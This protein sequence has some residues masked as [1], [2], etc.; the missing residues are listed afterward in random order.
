MNE[1]RRR[2]RSRRAQRAGETLPLPPIAPATS[3]TPLRGSAQAR[4]ARTGACITACTKGRAWRGHGPL[5]PPPPRRHCCCCCRCRCRR[6]P[7]KAPIEVEP[8]AAAPRHKCQAQTHDCRTVMDPRRLHAPLHA[9]IQAHAAD[10]SPASAAACCAQ[11]GNASSTTR[12]RHLHRSGGRIHS[13]VALRTSRTA[14]SMQHGVSMDHG[15]GR[16][17]AAALQAPRPSCSTCPGALRAP[18]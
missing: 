1:A 2:R 4:T 13:L 11:A 18:Q 14:A 12:T 5:P 6:W 16:D 7:M 3:R 9:A 8:W 17:I 15:A 10:K